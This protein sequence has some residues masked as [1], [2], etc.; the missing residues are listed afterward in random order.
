MPSSAAAMIA[1][2]LF[3][4]LT[5]SLLADSRAKEGARRALGLSADRWYRLA[6]TILAFVSVLPF[7]YIL[8]FMPN[9]I[10]YVI[11]AP[12]M[13]LMLLGQ[14][15]AAAALLYALVQTGFFYFLGVSQLISNRTEEPGKLVTSGFYCHIRNPLFLFGAIFLWLFPIMTVNLLAF[16]ILSTLYFYLG[17]LHEEKS[18]REEFGQEYEEYR[19]KVPM[20]LPRIRC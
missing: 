15:L 6:Y 14:A 8:A 1:Y 7:F 20:F 12:W 13:W 5:H 18:L 2:Y 17:A 9:T 10:L 11:P 4:A 16:N 3:F 19:R